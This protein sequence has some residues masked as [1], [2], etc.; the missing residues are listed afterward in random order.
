MSTDFEDFRMSHLVR[1]AEDWKQLVSLGATEESPLD[2]DFTF[3]S[4]SKD[5]IAD[6]EKELSD[7]S[8]SVSSEGIFKKKFTI[9]G[10][11]GAIAWNESRLLQ[12]VDYLIQVG[13]DSGCEF[14]GCGASAP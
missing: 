12:W 5:A 14:E 7:Y 11:S 6:L 1:T 9:S 10:N 4:T 3:I 13:A 2:F 8:L